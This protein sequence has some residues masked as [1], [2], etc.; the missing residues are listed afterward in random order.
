MTWTTPNV[1]MRTCVSVFI[2]VCT[3]VGVCIYT[4]A[5]ILVYFP[6]TYSFS[7]VFLF[8]YL[9]IVFFSRLHFRSALRDR[10]ENDAFLSVL[11]YP[12]YCWCYSYMSVSFV[13]FLYFGQDLD[14]TN[15]VI[16][17]VLYSFLWL[18]FMAR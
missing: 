6:L 10:N 16:Y 2:N 7:C 9:L 15:F 3:P 18:V 11:C 17:Q 12:N 5:N 14:L 8:A 1:F 4:Y 13:C